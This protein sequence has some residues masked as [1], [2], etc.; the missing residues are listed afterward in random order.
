MFKTDVRKSYSE[1]PPL[2]VVPAAGGNRSSRATCV[3]VSL[4]DAPDQ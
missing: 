3:V 1:W 4:K 2:K